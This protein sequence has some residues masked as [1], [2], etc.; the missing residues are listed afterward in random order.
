MRSKWPLL[1][2]SG[3]HGGE[4][5]ALLGRRAI[6]RVVA[7]TR[8]RTQERLAMQHWIDR[9]SIDHRPMPKLG[10]SAEEKVARKR[11]ALVWAPKTGA[12]HAVVQAYRQARDRGESE[13][14]APIAALC[15]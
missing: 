15:S 6:A 13:V 5:T 1:R 4:V 12:V 3:W 7:R 2:F 9:G 11:E 10:E 8:V 14:T